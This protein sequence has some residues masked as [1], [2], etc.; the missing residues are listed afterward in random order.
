M[1]VLR[2]ATLC[3]KEL[4]ELLTERETAFWAA[5]YNGALGQMLNLLHPEAHLVLTDGTTLGYADA[6]SAPMGRFCE[7]AQPADA[8]ICLDFLA[9]GLVQL[10]YQ[11]G[12]GQHRCLRT[13]IWGVDPVGWRLRFHQE[14]PVPYTTPSME[15]V[16]ALA[17]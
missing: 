9:P 2:S 4:L 6:L 5:L 10:R 8:P 13:S 17:V 3:R 7:Q 16:L 12:A 15:S 14:T 1:T 11:S